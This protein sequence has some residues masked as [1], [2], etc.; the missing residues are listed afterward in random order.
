MN[1][2][3]WFWFVAIVALISGYALCG[4]LSRR[5]AGCTVDDWQECRAAMCSQCEYKSL[6]AVREA[7]IAAL[8]ED[9]SRLSNRN[10]TLWGYVK[11]LKQ[12]RA[13]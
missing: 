9:I 4:R 6:V 2:L 3:L 5:K 12:Q 13:A 1:D 10:L 11:R 7:D 8:R